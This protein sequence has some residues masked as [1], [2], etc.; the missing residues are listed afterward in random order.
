APRTIA[1]GIFSATTRSAS[2]SGSLSHTAPTTVSAGSS[3]AAMSARPAR[4]RMSLA[5]EPDIVVGHR[6]V[7]I[8]RLDG[9][10]K[11]ASVI[12]NDQ[13][14]RSCFKNVVGAE[15][16]FAAARRCVDHEMRNR[17]AA[18]VAAQAVHQLHAERGRRA[19]MVGAPRRIALEQVIRPYAALEQLA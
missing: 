19:Q 5:A 12:A 14:I 16:Q 2:N 8:L 18:G 11:L 4:T 10:E 1:S 3:R 6:T 17:H 13:S 7:A 15:R 9:F